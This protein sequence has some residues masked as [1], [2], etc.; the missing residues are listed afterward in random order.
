MSDNSTRSRRSALFARG[1]WTETSRTR[2]ILRKETVGG[3]LLLLG[4]RR[5]PGLGELAVVRVLRGARR[6]ARRLRRLR[7]APE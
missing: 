2:R 4:Y 7:S 5:R 1:S 6:T 3:A